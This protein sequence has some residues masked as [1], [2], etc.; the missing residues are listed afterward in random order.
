M[1]LTLLSVLVGKYTD[2]LSRFV[3]INSGTQLLSILE[4][5]KAISTAR[6]V[7]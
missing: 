3:L 2:I 6:S 1:K 4:I 5:E 7:L